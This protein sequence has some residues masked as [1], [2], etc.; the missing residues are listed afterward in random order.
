MK[1]LTYPTALVLLVASLGGCSVR[2]TPGTL[3]TMGDDP[4][5]SVEAGNV[6]V[7]G[8][9]MFARYV[10]DRA[11]HSCWLLLGGQPTTLDCC[12]A[13]RVEALTS[14]ITWETDESCSAR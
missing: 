5:V 2:M 7:N 3:H 9:R 6:P 14:V 8:G 10:V 12:G 1:K 11:T 13:R 4:F